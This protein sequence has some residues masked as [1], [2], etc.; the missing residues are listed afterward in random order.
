MKCFEYIATD[1][2]GRTVRGTVEAD[3]WAAACGHLSARGL[4]NCR[5]AT[6]DPS[7]PL[8]SADAV[9]LAAY[10]SALAK[11]GLPLGEGLRAAAK[12]GASGP[13][14]NTLLAL[15][16]RIDA[17]E[18]LESAIDSIGP[19]LPAHLRAMMISGARS[20]HLAESLDGLLTHERDM[21][22]MTRWFWQATLY[23]VTLFAFLVGW[24]L[25]VSIWLR[26]QFWILRVLDDFGTGHRGSTAVLSIFSAIPYVVLGGCVAVALVVFL[27]YLIGGKPQL[28]SLAARIPLMGKAWRYQSLADFSGLSSIF[29]DHQLRLDEALRL[30]AESARDPAIRVASSRVADQ[31]Q[32]GGDL[33]V[34]LARSGIFP[35]TLVNLVRW[36]D[37]RS[38]LANALRTAREMYAERFSLQLRLARL[39]LPPVVFVMIFACVWFVVFAAFS[40][41]I[42]FITDLS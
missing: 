18:S 20:G 21:E 31:V 34:G 32:A 15:G 36:S 4:R 2:N 12:D 39:I 5:Q 30:V 17:G 27:S 7:R 22:D 3:D 19:L 10:V 8:N 11:A 33:S 24:L 1:E 9:E 6:G 40:P 29:L 13:L 41:L 23:P 42:K 28:S 26:P 14:S 37:E 25:F 16:E 38:A 35:A